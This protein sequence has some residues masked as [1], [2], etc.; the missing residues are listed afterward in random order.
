MIGKISEL[1]IGASGG[2][3]ESLTNVKRILWEPIPREYQAQTVMNIVNPVGF[4]RPHK[5]IRGELHVLSEAYHAFK[6]NG[7]GN[8]AYIKPSDEN[9][10]IPYFVA[11]NKD[12]N[13][14]DWTY[15]FTG[16]VPIDD[17]GVFTDGEDVIH[18]YPFVAK[19]VTETPP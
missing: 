4:R 17:P 11:K 13:G 19:Y 15:T 12:D 8:V 10:E 16:L 7:T 9:V 18:V 5:H 3:N 14:G 1:K 6:H 2:D